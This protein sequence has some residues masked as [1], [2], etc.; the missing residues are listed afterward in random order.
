MET[1]KRAH[2]S[3]TGD[4]QADA[5]P[6]CGGKGRYPAGSQRAGQ[7]CELCAGAGFLLRQRLDSNGN[8]TRV[9]ITDDAVPGDRGSDSAGNTLRSS[10]STATRVDS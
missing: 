3:E 5:C 10:R 1:V 6:I 9:L 2:P 8:P 4:S 7:P